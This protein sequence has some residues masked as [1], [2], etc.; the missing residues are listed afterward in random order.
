MVCRLITGR[1][2]VS[3]YD[4]DAGRKVD[5]S[6][7]SDFLKEFESKHGDY[8]TGIADSSNYDYTSDSGL[9]LNIFISDRTFIVHVKG[10]SAY[11]IGNV[12]NDS[13]HVYDHKASKGFLF[14]VLEFA[15]GQKPGGL[16]AG[17]ARGS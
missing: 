6:E 11:F 8:V 7:S 10:S 17:A 14:R 3:L 13:I 5:L 15:G 1:K 2:I 9:S 4:E 16:P 12:R